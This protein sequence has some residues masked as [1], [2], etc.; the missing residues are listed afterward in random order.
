MSSDNTSATIKALET[1]LEKIRTYLHAGK[2]VA[3]VGAGFSLNAEGVNGGKMK[4]WKELKGDMFRFLYGRDGAE[5]ELSEYSPV[6]LA[7]MVEAQGKY[8]LNTV[9]ANALPDNK[10]IPGELHTMLM[11]LPWHD[12][13][14]TNYDTLLERA[15]EIC[16]A[17]YK[18]VTCTDM[19][20]YTHSPRI[21]KL[22][23]SFE[24]KMPF[25]MSEED[26]RTYPQ[27]YPQFVNTVRQSLIENMMVLI[28]FSGDDPNFH[29]WLGW[30]R[31]VLGKLMIKVPLITYKEFIHPAELKYFADNNIE[32]I[33]LHTI[34][35]DKD[36]AAALEY[37]FDYIGKKNTS[38]NWKCFDFGMAF[39]KKNDSD[40]DWKKTIEQLKK[41]HET[42]PKWVIM[43]KEYYEKTNI[44]E[45]PR[46]ESKFNIM[47]EEYRF[48]FLYELTWTIELSLLPKLNSWYITALNN[49][50]RR[51]ESHTGKK[52]EQAIDMVLTLYG[53]YREMHDTTN[54]DAIHKIL[55]G[56]ERDMN[57][58]Q[59]DKF[60]YEQCL[61]C[62]STMNHMS[63]YV[64]LNHWELQN[65]DYQG[66]LWKASVYGEIGERE[67]ADKLLLTF[68][69]RLTS[70]Y[71]RDK[72]SQEL[73]SLC[74]IY[75]FVLSKDIL[76]K[77][78][79]IP[80][81]GENKIRAML[82]RLTGD[83]KDIPE[84]E[85]RP[86][87]N[88]WGRIDS[89]HLDGG[90]FRPI[91]KNA[92]RYLRLSY[93][94]GLKSRK[95]GI[96]IFSPTMGDMIG[97]LAHYKQYYPMVVDWAI[98]L[99][100]G[101]SLDLIASRD[102]LGELEDRT[103]E[104]TYNRIKDI[105]D[106]RLDVSDHHH[107]TIAFNFLIP[108]LVRLCCRG[109]DQMVED[110]FNIIMRHEKDLRLEQKSLLSSLYSYANQKTRC[111]FLKSILNQPICFNF[112]KCD[113]QFPKVRN[114]RLNMSEAS[115]LIMEEYFRNPNTDV[116]AYHLAVIALNN[117][118][119]KS[120]RNRL[121]E[122]I[123]TWRKSGASDVNSFYSYKTIKA[124]DQDDEAVYAKWEE[125]TFSE[126]IN[127]DFIFKGSSKN[128]EDF[129]KAL[130]NIDPQLAGLTLEKRISILKKILYVL[131]S[132]FSKLEKDDSD[133]VYGGFRHFSDDV[134]KQ[135]GFMLNKLSMK[136]IPVKLKNELFNIL[137][138]YTSA[139][140]PC[141]CH[142]VA[143]ARKK[144][145]NELLSIA[146]E[147]MMA[148]Q[149]NIREDASKAIRLL[150]KKGAKPIYLMRQMLYYIKYSKSP[151]IAEILHLLGLLV[152]DNSLERQEIQ[153]VYKA[154]DTVYTSLNT[155][156][157]MPL[158]N[159]SE[160]IHE[161]CFLTGVL[162]SHHLHNKSM[163]TWKNYIKSDGVFRDVK[164]GYEQG[165]ELK[166][167]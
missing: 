100:Q 21:I 13:F 54:Y 24:D 108:M 142:M 9:I 113:V 36:Y 34:V 135:M 7:S 120:Q 84:H 94:S 119:I 12:V 17:A 149:R 23:G 158:T 143:V 57:S 86:S 156:S 71:L 87:F 3:M 59:K 134:F 151:I 42:Y 19:L 102:I 46:L 155:Y 111:D 112:P 114:M 132:N 131:D 101:K 141:L 44:E 53:Y 26:F 43:P 73:Y 68:Y 106:N 40:E 37:F 79:S 166:D 95:M 125:K 123:V 18:K 160:I 51:L 74:Q 148:P 75:L 60:Y 99:G 52:K 144:D 80:L 77:V 133:D 6:R 35:G 56:H 147:R 63:V 96:I 152:H 2:A 62:L 161:S 93:L 127:G 116:F 5:K 82:L 70:N 140:H 117:N 11:R 88:L 31:D 136:N 20:P 30:I 16:G 89:Y 67:L 92:Y 159:K 162:T 97:K 104:D 154:L 1:S 130:I 27:K 128:L 107:A 157:S 91:F 15:G 126:L 83:A 124:K 32:V 47:P 110:T 121:E 28:G 165:L 55:Q 122:M 65:T 145:Y 167:A 115:L 76:D 41:A 164:L 105:I 85:E 25:I 103:I 78:Y 81:E 61:W 98:R 163:S 129:E 146:E 14:T 64:L 58:Q 22:H 66:A 69:S 153:F 48:D 109:T 33:N 45:Y 38:S 10:V 138:R 118:L 72:D 4:S 8:E 139:N 137:H 50:L 90:G 29:S 150:M 39:P 49:E